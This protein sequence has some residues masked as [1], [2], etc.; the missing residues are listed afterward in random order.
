MHIEPTR[1]D[2]YTQYTHYA[3]IVTRLNKRRNNSDSDRLLCS[4]Y[5]ESISNI[6]KKNTHTLTY[7]LFTSGKRNSFLFQLHCGCVFCWAKLKTL[8]IAYRNF[9]LRSSGK[10]PL[11]G[12]I[13]ICMCIA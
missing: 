9:K 12:K 4:A 13:P 3:H 7:T 1:L 8:Q 11:I 5:G 10:Y 2:A 6:H